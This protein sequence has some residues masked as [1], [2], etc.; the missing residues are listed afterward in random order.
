MEMNKTLAIFA[1][2]SLLSLGLAADSHAGSSMA[3]RGFAEYDSTKLV[4][5]IVRSLDGEEL[6]RIS[7][8]E[9]DSQGHV[10][11]ALILQNGSNGFSGR[12][13]AVPFNALT[14]S[15]AKSQQIQVRLNVEKEDF[16]TAPSFD[17]KDLDNPQWVTEL[18]RSFGQ[19]PYW[20]EEEAGKVPTS[21]SDNPCAYPY[22]LLT[23]WDCETLDKPWG[24]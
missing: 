16:Y 15:E 20:T 14:I 18:Y 21:P 19:Q 24:K 7:D 1:V 11:L 6:G 5:S 13:V 4:G 10:I 8:L 12:L 3:K 17:S 9:I 23:K 22:S 2:Y